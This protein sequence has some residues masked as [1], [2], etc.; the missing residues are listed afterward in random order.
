MKIPIVAYFLVNLILF[1]FALIPSLWE[2]PWTVVFAFLVFEAL[3]E[4]FV[5]GGNGFFIIRQQKIGKYI[6][7]RRR[8]L[9]KG[10][11]YIAFF[12]TILAVTFISSGMTAFAVWSVDTNLTGYWSG[13]AGREIW[14]LVIT[15]GLYGS[16]KR[17][18]FLKD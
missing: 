7:V 5:G 6:L 8:T 15:G 12:L 1:G 17:G 10:H 18:F 9:T 2:I 4:I 14:N 3:M 16:L 11:A 13:V